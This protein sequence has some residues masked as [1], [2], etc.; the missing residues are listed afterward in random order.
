MNLMEQLQSIWKTWE[1]LWQ[2][3]DMAIAILKY[4]PLVLSL[5]LIP[6]SFLASCS[7]G[8]FRKLMIMLC[9]FMIAGIVLTSGITTW[10]G[11][12]F[13]APTMENPEANIWWLALIG[14]DVLAIACFGNNLWKSIGRLLF[15]FLSFAF[16]GYII[17]IADSGGQIAH[18]NQTEPADPIPD[19]TMPSD[20]TGDATSPPAAKNAPTT[21]TP[22]PSPPPPKPITPAQ[23]TAAENQAKLVLN[24]AGLYEAKP[25]V[26]Y[27]KQVNNF[28]PRVY[29]R[30]STDG[31]VRSALR[32]LGGELPP[33]NEWGTR[34]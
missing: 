25:G 27:L 18:G 26:W 20:P 6:F 13:S 16:A 8:A 21:A 15:F 19:S 31:D 4:F 30:L 7:P 34:P 23:P 32:T 28:S 1:Q 29:N 22:I 10:Q 33:R 24:Q 12:G 9:F 11:T 17:Q 2:N 3:P 14:A 5:L